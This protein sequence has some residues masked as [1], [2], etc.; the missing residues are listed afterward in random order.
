MEYAMIKQNNY[1][2]G[3][4]LTLKYFHRC[5]WDRYAKLFNHGYFIGSYFNFSK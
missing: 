4:L 3:C 2:N 1:S 5:S